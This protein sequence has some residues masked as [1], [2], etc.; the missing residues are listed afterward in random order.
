MQALIVNHRSGLGHIGVQRINRRAILFLDDAAFQF[1][2][3]G[4]G[5]VVKSEIGG[6]QREAF[7]GFILRE[8]RCQ[9]VNFRANQRAGEAMRGNFFSGSGD[10]PLFRRFRGNRFPADVFNKSFL[11]SVINK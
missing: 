3:E 8:V 4:K 11:R 7:D 1:H 6:K 2:G 9:P 10:N 5:A